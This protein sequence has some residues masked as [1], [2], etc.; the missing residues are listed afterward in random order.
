MWTSFC[1]LGVTG[2]SCRLRWFNQLDPRINRRPFTEEEEE[3]LLAAHRIHGNKWAL[4][5][6]LFPGRTD[7]AVKNH[8]HVIMARKQREQT[9]LSCT[10]TASAKRSYQELC[11]NDDNSEPSHINFRA[12]ITTSQG[13]FK[14]RSGLIESTR[15]FQLQNPNRDHRSSSLLLS[16]L[17]NNSNNNSISTPSSSPSWNFA[18][19][20]TPSS[21]RSGSSG[22]EGIIRDFFSSNYN[23]YNN[24]SSE[25]SKG[26]NSDHHLVYRVLP[27]STTGSSWYTSFGLQNYKRVHVSSSPLGCLNLSHHDH[28]HD[29]L[30]RYESTHGRSKKSELA[31][32]GS[33]TTIFQ[34]IKEDHD[35]HQESMGSQQVPSFIDFLGVGI[36]SWI[37]LITQHPFLFN[38]FYLLFQI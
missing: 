8:W 10:N 26:S 33:S 36:S 4:I 32:L 16:A 18:S 2:K 23:N 13:E 30:H 3:R 37:L 25:C 11:M 27:N 9:K 12:R 29:H 5:A 31:K 17:D 35:H 34:G 38:L 22:R 19:I 6:R 14:L 28:D 24:I 21:N 15:L 1:I 7:N 20:G